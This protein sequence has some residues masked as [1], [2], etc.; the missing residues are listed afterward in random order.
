MAKTG[1]DT[2]GDGS[3]TSPYLTIGKAN[4]IAGAS[5]R[6]TH[7]S[8]GAGTYSELVT[9]PRSNLTYNGVGA[10]IIDGNSGAR[11]GFTIT[12]SDIT[13]N[14][15]DCDQCLVGVSSSGART[16]VRNAVITNV[17]TGLNFTGISPLVEDIEIGPFISRGVYLYNGVTGAIQRRV[18]VHDGTS[19]TT[20]YCF[21][22]ELNADGALY[23][24]CW[25][26]NAKY[27]FINKASDGGI[28]R[29]CVA[30][31]MASAGFYGKGGTNGT[32][33]NCVAYDANLGVTLD[34]NA[35]GDPSTGWTLRNNILSA[36]TVAGLR[37][38]N[39]S[40]TNLDSDYND[41]HGNGNV[42]VI[43][44]NTY[45]TLAE[46]QAGESLDANS[47]AVDPDYA[48]VVYG[49]FVPQSTAVLAGADDGGPQGHTG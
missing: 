40:D 26:I 13:I 34:D 43:D 46:L 31:D 7:I 37:A 29:R 41:L 48:S 12:V 33:V 24:D 47:Q 23:E 18:Y 42:A 19:E 27:G 4:A 36:N 28:Y 21:E 22:A 39:G 44:V 14:G 49:G 6:W 20:A 45:N 9:P 17:N 35:G 15:I 1:D 10:V 11:N 8:I 2:T 3:E 5:G 32:L 16:T 30:S 38:I 25:A